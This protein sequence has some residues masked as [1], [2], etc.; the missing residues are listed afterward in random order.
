[1]L[2]VHG[3][4]VLS[5]GSAHETRDYAQIIAVTPGAEPLYAH[6]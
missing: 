2:G 1:M 4:E 3:L 5:P 6:P